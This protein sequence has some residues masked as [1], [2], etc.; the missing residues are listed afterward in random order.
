[1]TSEQAVEVVE[2]L[3]VIVNKLVEVNASLWYLIQFAV[4]GLALLLVF[5]IGVFISK[6]RKHW[7]DHGK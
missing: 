4:F 1:M 2:K 5:E 3:T 6:A 7:K